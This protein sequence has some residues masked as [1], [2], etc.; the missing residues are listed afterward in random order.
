MEK[1]NIVFAGTPDF[2]AKHLSAL[3]ESQFNVVAVYT[4]PDRPAGRGKKL[5]ASAVK[6]LAVEHDLP[7]YQPE[8][9]KSEESVATLASLNADLMIV[10]AYGLILP[11]NV[12]N[13]P[14]LGCLNVHGSLL[15]RWRGAA[16]IQ[17]SIWAGDKETGVTI[18]Q[19]NEGLD[20]GDMLSKVVCPIASHETS[21]TLYEK[22]AI[23][24]PQV[25]VET[26]E[27]LANNELTAEVQDETLANY[28]KKLS[29]AEALIDWSQDAVFIDRCVRAFNPWPMSYF[30]LAGKPIK[31]HQV[32]IIE[33][34][35]S[36]PIGTIISADKNGI[37]VATGNGILN[38]QVL[39]LAGKKAMPVQDILNSRKELFA[40]GTALN[41]QG[42]QG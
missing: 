35:S 41:A 14:R 11:T 13:T 37:Q 10:V 38:L 23:Q 25:L 34:T 16:P 33:E 5:T 24:A 30:E 19:M 26:I 40:P 15:P 1:L 8:N 20:T 18:M 32:S 22:L 36:Q 29:K 3:I 31:V 42:V 6:Q 12:L 39:Q 21:S 7:V 27:K 4:Q 17:R 9:F 28:A 2:A